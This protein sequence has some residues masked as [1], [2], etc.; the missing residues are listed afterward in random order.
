MVFVNKKTKTCCN[1]CCNLTQATRILGFLCL[2]AALVY[3]IS[4]RWLGFTIQL[5]LGVALLMT[6]K[7]PESVKLRKWLFKGV[8]VHQ[9]IEV[10]SFFVIIVMIEANWSSRIDFCSTFTPSWS[11]F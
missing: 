3:A 11:I 9:V 8:F 4:T 10:L 2:L 5:F 1:G 7:W 6:Y